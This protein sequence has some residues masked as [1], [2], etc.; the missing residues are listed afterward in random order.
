MITCIRLGGSTLWCTLATHLPSLCL[1]VLFTPS[2]PWHSSH[3]PSH[4]P[5]TSTYS[6]S[7]VCPLVEHTPHWVL[8]R[9]LAGDNQR[10]LIPYFIRSTSS[11]HLH[12]YLLTQHIHQVS[13]VGAGSSPFK[14]GLFTLNLFSFSTYI[15]PKPAHNVK[16]FLALFALICAVGGLS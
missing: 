8:C 11:I 5:S 4:R 9:W 14:R 10:I 15:I 12:P 16:S 13:S 2:D 3:S 6:A 1:G 7:Y